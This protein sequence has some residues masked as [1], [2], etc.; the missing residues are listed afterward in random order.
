MAEIELKKSLDKRVNNEV[1]QYMAALERKE[2]PT[3]RILKK[4]KLQTRGFQ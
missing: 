2:V 3:L 1:D 4:P